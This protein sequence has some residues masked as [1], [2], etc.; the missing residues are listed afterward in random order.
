MLEV[1]PH[2]VR[3]DVDGGAVLAHHG[4]LTPP[5]QSALRAAHRRQGLDLIAVL[6]FAL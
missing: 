6:A 4:P 1:V 5:R 2:G 3:R